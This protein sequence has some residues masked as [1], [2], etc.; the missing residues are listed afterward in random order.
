M[1][2]I[3]LFGL[4]GSGKTTFTR[5][6]LGRY[7][8]SHVIS[9][10]QF[11]I[12][13]EGVYVFDPTTE[14]KVCKKFFTY[15]YYFSQANADKEGIMIIDDANIQEIQLIQLLLAIDNI[16]N[17]LYFVVFDSHEIEV[18]ERRM[19]ENGHIL[20]TPKFRLFLSLY[21]NLRKLIEESFVRV[22]VHHPEFDIFEYQDTDPEEY[23]RLYNEKCTEFYNEAIEML[24]KMIKL[25]GGRYSIFPTETPSF[26]KKQIITHLVPI[27]DVPPPTLIKQTVMK[28][29]PDK[30]KQKN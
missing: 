10:D 22:T 8:E 11:R 16:N 23:Y 25:G 2:Y 4:P 21:L 9:R 15:L 19:H 29:E 12:N 13:S 6:L 5:K 14:D 20:D 3:I 30:K 28:E 27:D 24:D 18:H 17:E 7:P 26:P 1:R